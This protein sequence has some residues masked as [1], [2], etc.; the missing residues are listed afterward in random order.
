MN[1]LFTLAAIVVAV[2]LVYF[3]IRSKMSTGGESS[4]KDNEITTVQPEEGLETVRDALRKATDAASCRSA[5]QQLNEYLSRH[6]DDQP[7]GLAP[8][9]LDVLKTRFQ[10]DDRELSEVQSNTF[11][12]LDAHYLDFSFLLH[13]ALDSMHIEKLPPLQQ[14]TAAFNWVVREIRLV[15]TTAETLPPEFVLRRGYG[16]STE[17]AL[18]FLGLL[19]Q[20]GIDSCRVAIPGAGP[21]DPRLRYWAS[22]V[23][24]DGQIYLFDTALGLPVPGSKGQGT[25]TLAQVMGDPSIVNVL[26]VDPKHPYQA[27]PDEVK[28]SEVHVACV[29]SALA[30]RMRFVQQVLGAGEKDRLNVDGMARWQHFV[31]ATKSI[32]PA[33][34]PLHGWNL[35]G[36]S[37]S[38]I[39]VSYSSLPPDDG[40]TDTTHRMEV[41]RQQLIQWGFCPRFILA[42]PGEPGGRLRAFYASPFLH[43]STEPKMPREEMTAWLP[44]IAAAG[45][46]DDE[47]RRTSELIQ[48]ERL[49]RDLVLRGRFDEATTLLVAF[50]DELRRQRGLKTKPD[51]EADARAWCDRATQVYGALLAA[52]QEA[53]NPRANLDPERAARLEVEKN[54][55]WTQEQK[56]IMEAILSASSEP[57][58]GEVIYLLALCKQEQA[59]R[60]KAP[61]GDR[62]AYG[63]AWK[64]A[65]SWWATYLDGQVPIASPG[66]A[67]RWRALALQAL[68]QTDAAVTLLEDLSGEL[69]EPDKV[70]HLYL[71]KKLK[72]SKGSQ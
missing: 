28:R 39:R 26:T 9:A 67:R 52:Q 69:V 60:T 7:P 62:S 23:L 34:V 31:A 42:V 72:E 6:P 1:R 49:P 58:S 71:A 11:T 68:G 21:N 3:G 53:R 70:A 43:F 47:S 16:T 33:G 5:V 12:L 24:I 25:A 36:D 59:V 10:L 14:A 45:G 66:S 56:P 17:R 40:G 37:T 46:G 63:Q 4:I 54:R 35:P 41:A 27:K 65:A 29:L 57:L 30:P 22:G 55:L 61:D 13:D 64:S 38:P 50:D 51:F 2:V 18:V 44:G 48:R 32:G 19:D 8:E 15:G 20:L